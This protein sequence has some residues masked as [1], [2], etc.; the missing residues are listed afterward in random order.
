M[1]RP[2]RLFLVAAEES[3]DVLGGALMGAL[4][5]RQSD[6]AFSGVGGRAMQSFGLNSLFDPSDVSIIGAASIPRKL[7]LIFRRI[8]ETA[9]AAIAAQPDAL[10]I[11]DSPD[12]T[13]RVARRVRKGAPGIPI[14]NYAPPTVWAWRPWRAR[15][16]RAYVDEV[17]AILPFEPAAFARLGGPPCTYVGHPL[18]ERVADLRPKATELRRTAGTPLVLVLPGSRGS[19]IRRLGS[20]FGEALALTAD[21]AGAIDVVLPTLPHLA[22]QVARTTA[23]WAVHP[24]V[25]VAPDEK[26]AAFREARAALAASGTVTLELALGHVP[27]VTAY[28]VPAWEGAVFR[29]MAHIDTVILAN[30]VLG[31]NVVPEFLQGDCTPS[32]LATGLI[33]L[34]HDTEGRR[35]QLR[36]FARLDR[37]MDLSGE[38]PS[39]RAAQAVLA[40]IERK[41]ALPS[42]SG[43]C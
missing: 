17:L 42:L 37:I 15:G 19:E 11:I 27:M 20:I 22:G 1:S 29:L 12:F 32:Q 4:R 31:E 23:N 36:A 35:R 24:R 28:R 16:M 26:Y 5:E 10:I 21:R 13:H 7:P 9:D 43:S 2:L 18:A 30:L 6:V 8:R 40:G 41:T 33:P 39:R 14:F 34:L 25:V 38:P 3:G